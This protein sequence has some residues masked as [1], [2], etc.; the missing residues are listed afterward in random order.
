MPADA[1]IGLGSTYCF[2]YIE[3]NKSGNEGNDHRKVECS[4]PNGCCSGIIGYT[5][6]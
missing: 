5:D 3:L 4:F 1:S 6:T 2:T